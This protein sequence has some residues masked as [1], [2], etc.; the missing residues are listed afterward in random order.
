VFDWSEPGFF[1]GG[2]GSGSV[3]RIPL[4]DPPVDGAGSY[5]VPLASSIRFRLCNMN[6]NGGRFLG[7]GPQQSTISAENSGC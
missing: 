3:L 5:D 1:G 6:V 4:P 7:S 2:A